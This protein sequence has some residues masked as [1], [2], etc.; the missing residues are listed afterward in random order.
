MVTGAMTA[1]RRQP[2]GTMDERRALGCATAK[3]ALWERPL[4]DAGVAEVFQCVE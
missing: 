4:H 3:R 2:S 1:P